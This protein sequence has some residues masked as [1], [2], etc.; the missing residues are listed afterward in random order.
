MGRLSTSNISN[1]FDT[2]EIAEIGMTW[3]DDSKSCR[4]AGYARIASNQPNTSEHLSSRSAKEH[5]RPTAVVQ[6][7]SAEPTGFRVFKHGTCRQQTCSVIFPWS[8]LRPQLGL[9]RWQ[10]CDWRCPHRVSHGSQVPLIWFHDV[11][12]LFYK[13]RVTFQTDNSHD[14]Q[15]PITTH[16]A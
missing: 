16:S 7:L 11:S 5:S 14:N 10:A 12:W 2:F 1:Q 3:N 9:L 4:R 8:L 6:C 15:L 13:H